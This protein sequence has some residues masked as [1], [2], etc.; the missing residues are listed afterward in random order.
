MSDTLQQQQT[1][2]SDATAEEG[3]YYDGYGNVAK[4]TINEGEAECRNI[5]TETDEPYQ[6]FSADEDPADHGYN[7]VADIAVENPLRVAQEV[8]NHGYTR[9]AE[10]YVA[11]Q[12][13][14]VAE[15]EFIDTVTEISLRDE[16]EHL[17]SNE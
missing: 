2:Q 1:E 7:K 14:G 5:D 8:Y 15:F 11:D 12:R 16:F 13:C 6:T 9:D 3:Y 17:G 10:I 4:I